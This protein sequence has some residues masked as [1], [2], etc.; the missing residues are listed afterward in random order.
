MAPHPPPAPPPRQ[1]QGEPPRASGRFWIFL[2]VFLV[3]L[4]AEFVANDRPLARPLPGRAGCF[5]VFRFY[6]E[7]DF[8]GEFQ[9]EAEYNA[10][11][12]RCL[13]AHRRRSRPAST[14][15]R[16]STPR[17]RRPAPPTASRSPSPAGCSGRRSPSASTPSTTTS[18]PPPRRPT[19]PTGS[20]PT[21]RPATCSP[22]SSTASAS[23]CS[24]PSSSPSISSLIGIVAGACPGLLRRL[25]RPLLPAHRRDSGRTCRASTSSS[26]SRRSSR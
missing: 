3:T 16:A 10:P 24:S 9:T 8:G 17:R 21:T 2:A 22:A 19:A 12:V 14:T 15:P 5:P 4:C 18:S 26:S 1:L 7:A 25:G 11:E 23:R 13:I 20:A 6:S